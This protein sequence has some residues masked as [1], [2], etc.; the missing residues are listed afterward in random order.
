MCREFVLMHVAI[1]AGVD[2]E[3]LS[4]ALHLFEAGSL[5]EPELI[6]WLGW[7]AGESQEPSVSLPSAGI[8]GAYHHVQLFTWVSG[9]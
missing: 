7:L 6:N 1:K 3:C 9:I 4:L 8:T 2:A 5:S